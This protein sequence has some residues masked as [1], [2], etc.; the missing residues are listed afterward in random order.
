MIFDLLSQ[1]AKGILFSE[2][3][4]CHLET[5]DINQCAKRSVPHGQTKQW[6]CEP[7]QINEVLKFF[8]FK[9]FKFVHTACRILVP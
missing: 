2:A 1:H 6:E 4:G 5:M 7:R 8:F 3:K 9:E